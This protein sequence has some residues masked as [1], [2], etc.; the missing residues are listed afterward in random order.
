MPLPCPNCFDKT[1]LFNSTTDIKCESDGCG[2]EFVLVDAK[3]IR[4]K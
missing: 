4:Y 3:T 1:L 2:Q